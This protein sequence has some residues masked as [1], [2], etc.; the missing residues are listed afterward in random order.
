MN[1]SSTQKYLIYQL[2][3][4]GVCSQPI[5]ESFWN[6][7]FHSWY[8]SHL[9]PSS[10]NFFIVCLRVSHSRI[11]SST[12]NQTPFQ[13]HHKFSLKSK[14][15]LLEG[16]FL[17]SSLLPKCVCNVH[18]R[19]SRLV[20]LRQNGNRIK[21]SSTKRHLPEIPKNIKFIS[22]GSHNRRNR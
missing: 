18:H 9:I 2:T 16:N 6:K 19:I 17:R 13:I 7:T 20:Q 10:R 21:V 3:I 12:T 11:C 4:L 8:F 1:V 14:R 22:K 5:I 15:S